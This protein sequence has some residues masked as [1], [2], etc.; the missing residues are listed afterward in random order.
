MEEPRK[1]IADVTEAPAAALGHK[2]PRTHDT[3][4]K[5]A[6]IVDRRAV[7]ARITDARVEDT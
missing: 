6:G 2:V 7:V 4:D 3:R 5:E 1:P